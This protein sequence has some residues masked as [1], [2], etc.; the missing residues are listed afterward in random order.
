VRDLKAEGR[1]IREIA[2]HL[3]MSV[4]T[5]VRIL[6][7]PD[8]P[9]GRLGCRGP[10]LLDAYRKDVEAWLASDG[11]NTADLYRLLKAKGCRASYDATRRYA[12]HRLGSSGKP[13]RRSSTSTQKPPTPEIPSARKLSFEFACPKTKPHNSKPSVLDQ[14]RTQIPMLDVGLKV[15]GEF[16]SMIGRTMKTTL[17]DWLVKAGACGIPE[18]V[19]FASGLAEDA[20]AVSAALTEGWSNGPVEGQV[21]RL[22]AIKRSMYGRAGLTL[23]RARVL[24]KD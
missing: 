11:T 7:M 12:N 22:K 20:A 6:R 18:L 2:R 1:S 21:N 23:L 10:S 9:H 15:A 16:A 14:V 19:R 3:K 4:K 8:R 13:G 17:A 24:N 5:V